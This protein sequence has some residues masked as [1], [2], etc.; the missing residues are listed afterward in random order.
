MLVADRGLAQVQALTR[1]DPVGAARRELAERTELGFPPATRM[2]SVSGPAAAVADLLAGLAVGEVL[3]PVDDGEGERA[4][5]RVP[6]AQGQALA[7]ALKAA[8]G[9]RSARKAEPVRIE[10]DP[11]RLG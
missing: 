2:A 6:R 8:A 11:L 5:V 10:L 1:W 9:V 3:G 4:L 7:G